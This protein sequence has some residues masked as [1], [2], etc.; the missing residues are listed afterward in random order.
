MKRRLIILVLYLLPIGLAAQDVG[1]TNPRDPAAREKIKAAHTAF[2]TQQL[3]LTPEESEKFWPV[4]RDY[5]EKRRD[6]RQEI[7]AERKTQIKDEEVIARDL[8]LKQKE[9]D[10]EREYM[11]KLGRIIPA[12]NQVKFREAE[13]EFRRLIFRQIQQHRRQRR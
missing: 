10:L 5:N 12:E 9:L 2:I 1:P 4:Y 3:G 11:T 7:R 8:E 13:F 6:L